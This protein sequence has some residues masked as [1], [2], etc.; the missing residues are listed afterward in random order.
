[1]AVGMLISNFPKSGYRIR[2]SGINPDS[3]FVHKPTSADGLL[4]SNGGSV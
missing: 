4:I 3:D 1:M 2:K